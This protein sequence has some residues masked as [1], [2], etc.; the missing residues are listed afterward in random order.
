MDP[1][2]MLGILLHTTEQQSQTTDKLL[3]ELRNHVAA[4]E[5]ATKSAKDAS[6]AIQKAVGEAARKAVADSLSEAPKTSLEA[7]KAACQPVF[8]AMNEA[9]EAVDDAKGQLRSAGAWFSWQV[10]VIAAGLV[11]V[12]G[13]LGWAGIAWERH[14]VAALQEQKAVLQQDVAELD[15]KVAALAKRGGR[16]QITSCTDSVGVE[17]LCVQVS[18]NQGKGYEQY[19]APFSNSTSGAQFVVP[20]GY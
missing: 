12:A 7:F 2:K 16:I 11:A 3:A 19:K 5:A 13:V 17:R 1:Q 18:P 10:A 8:T 6:P 9:T 20:Q 4:L 15:A 14:Q